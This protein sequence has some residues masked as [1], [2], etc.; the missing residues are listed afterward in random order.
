MPSEKRGALLVAIVLVASAILGG[1]YGPSVRATAAGASDL[2]DSVKSFTQVLTVV[3][4]NY[5]IPVDTDKVVYDGAIPGMLRTLDPHSIFFDAKQFALMREEQEGRYYGVGMYIVPRPDGRVQ[6]VSAFVGSPAY[7]AGLKPGDTLIKIDDKSVVGKPSGDIADLLKGPAGTTVHIGVTREGTPDQITFSVTRAD[8]PKHDVDPPLVIRPGIGYIYIRSFQSEDTAEDFGDDLQKLAGENL[9]GL[10][11]D[12]RDN[13]GG[14]LNSAIGIGDDILDKN[15]LIVSQH[16]RVS[17]ERRYYA[18]HGNQGIRVPV[19]VLVNGNTASASEIVSGAIQD[20]DRGLIFGERTFG[21]GLVQSVTSLAEGTGLALTTAHYYTPSGRLIQRDYKTVSLFEYQFNHN[22]SVHQTEVKLTDSGRQVYGG[23]GITP[24]VEYTPPKPNDFQIRL[25]NY[26]N[27]VLVF[28][29][30]APSQDN[31]VGDFT[32]HYLGTHPTITK[33]FV[34]DDSII[35]QFRDFLTA[36]NI[37]YT[38]QDITDN[39]DWIKLHIKR[40]VFTYVFGQLEGYRVEAEGDPEILK[41]TDL[42]PQA[43]ALYDN[44]RRIV[45]E[46]TAQGPNR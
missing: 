5:A 1:I 45:A 6:V 11:L 13:G 32:T 40:E 7:K 4:Q 37:K 28:A 43:R 46:R 31:A 42:V 18:I 3:Q 34:V 44:A 2:Q 12:L 26:S 27:N 38:D 29:G 19:V 24:D 21:K 25:Q 20:H 36:H 15:Q 23:G 22:T 41:A 9:T 30:N 17:P 10:V 14:L 39:L 8:I 35:H 16:G 33:N